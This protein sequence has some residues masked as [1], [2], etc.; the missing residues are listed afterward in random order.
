[1]GACTDITDGIVM[2]F[3]FEAGVETLK[4]GLIAVGFFFAGFN[5]AL[6]SVFDPV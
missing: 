4:G 6:L 5:T 2:V 3:V 1:M